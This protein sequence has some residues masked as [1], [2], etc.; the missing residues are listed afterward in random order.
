MTAQSCSKCGLGFGSE[1]WIAKF[2]SFRDQGVDLHDCIVDLGVL[3]E[4][5]A[6]KLCNI[7]MGENID[8]KGWGKLKMGSTASLSFSNRWINKPYDSGVA[9]AEETF[10]DTQ[11]YKINCLMNQIYPIYQDLMFRLLN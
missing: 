4:P 9:L 3:T 11:V 1:R 5:N 7:I 8:Y 6:S 2:Q 10:D